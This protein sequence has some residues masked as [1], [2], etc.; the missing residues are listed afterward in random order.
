MIT[1]LT[2]KEKTLL[3]NDAIY[4]EMLFT[5]GVSS[6]DPADYCA[7]EHLNFSRMGHARALLYFFESTST[8]KKWKDDVVSEDFGFPAETISI[9]KDERDRLNKDLFHLSSQRLRH[10]RDS[11]PWTDTLL[12]QIH[13]R[14][15]CFVDFILALGEEH[16][17]EVARSAWEV[18]ASAMK[19]GREILI[20]RHLSINGND[21]GWILGLGRNLESGKSELTL[22]HAR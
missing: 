22:I 12:Q 9:S 8:A 20:R 11:K 21:S 17:F 10:T 1:T 13:E 2:P 16:D 3:L 18:L 14:S 15:V 5:F 19:S 6:H 4:Y 7:W